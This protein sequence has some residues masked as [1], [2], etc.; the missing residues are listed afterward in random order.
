MPR[1]EAR[2]ENRFDLTA[3]QRVPRRAPKCCSVVRYDPDPPD[4][5]ESEHDSALKVNLGELAFCWQPQAVRIG[6]VDLVAE[7]SKQ[8]LGRVRIRDRATP[9][10]QHL[11]S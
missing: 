11:A 2:A 5:I 3:A 8:P 7:A 1:D 4:D 6:R 10:C 9:A